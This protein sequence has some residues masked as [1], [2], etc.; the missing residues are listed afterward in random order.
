MRQLIATMVVAF[1]AACGGTDDRVQI[2]ADIDAATQDLIAWYTENKTALAAG[3]E[4]AGQPDLTQYI[5]PA[6]TVF[7]RDVQDELAYEALVFVLGQHSSAAATSAATE[8][9]RQRAMRLLTGAS[10]WPP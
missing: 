1:T 3:E 9:E 2:M 7:E 4:V 6:T 10:H 8:A 5:E